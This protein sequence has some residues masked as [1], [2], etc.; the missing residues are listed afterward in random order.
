MDLKEIKLRVRLF[1]KRFL[2]LTPFGVDTDAFSLC[3]FVY[4]TTLKL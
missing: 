1:Y 2:Y 3:L 4:L